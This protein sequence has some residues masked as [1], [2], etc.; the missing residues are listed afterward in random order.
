MQQIA[1][2]LSH[3]TEDIT[4]AQYVLSK[5][6]PKDFNEKSNSEEDGNPDLKFTCLNI[7]Q[8]YLNFYKTKFDN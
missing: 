7:S 6:F 4:I 5:G 8:N 3:I 1:N 2:G